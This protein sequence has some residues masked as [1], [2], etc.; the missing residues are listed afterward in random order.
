MAV[1][2]CSTCH[3]ADNAQ[4]RSQPIIRAVNRV[5]QPAAAAFVPTFAAQHHIEHALRADRLDDLADHAS[6]AL[7]FAAH[8]AQHAL[9]LTVVD[10][11]RLRLVARDITILLTLHVARY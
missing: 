2:A 5:S 6:M 1:R 3:A 4:D 8:F 10:G 9:S 7:F 11:A